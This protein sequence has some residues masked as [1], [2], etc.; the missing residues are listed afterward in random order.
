MIPSYLIALAKWGMNL[1]FWSAVLF[2]LL[3]GWVWP[4]WKSFW[5]MNILLLEVA[6]ALALLGSVIT[7][8]FGVHLIS[9]LMLAWTTTTSLWLVGIIIIWRGFLVISSQLRGT[10][11]SGFIVTL[12]K[13]RHQQHRRM[14]VSNQPN[15]WPKSEEEPKKESCPQELTRWEV[16]ACPA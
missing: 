11:G 4:W 16:T 7:T 15:H 2:V 3:S 5:G 13:L 10:F 9:N 8:D 12:K 1:A 14:T 6:I